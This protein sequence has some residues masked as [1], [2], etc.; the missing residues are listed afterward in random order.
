M[1]VWEYGE[2]LTAFLQGRGAALEDQRELRM[3][4]G[5][6][7]R[8]S[9]IDLL[10]EDLLRWA[11]EKRL[12]AHTVIDSHPVTREREY[13]FRVTAFSEE[14]LRRLSPDEIWLFYVS[15]EVTLRRIELDPAGRPAITVEEARMHSAAQAAVACTFGIVAGCPVYMF[16]TDTNQHALVERLVGRL[17]D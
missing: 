6:F 10:D 1:H 13:G 15:P 9:D 7:S 12:T 14:K 4:S 16:D 11:S 3:R 2:R 8:P 17:N 5:E